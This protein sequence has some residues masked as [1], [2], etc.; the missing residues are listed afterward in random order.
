VIKEYGEASLSKNHMENVDGQVT[1]LITVNYCYH[2]HLGGFPCPIIII[3]QQV[4]E[5]VVVVHKA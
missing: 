3:R 1:V 5:L 2:I 4:T